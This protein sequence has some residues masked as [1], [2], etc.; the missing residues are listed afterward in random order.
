[1]KKKTDL[2]KNDLEDMATRLIPKSELHP[3]SVTEVGRLPAFYEKILAFEKIFD[4]PFGE[5]NQKF[6]NTLIMRRLQQLINTLALNPLWKDRVAQAGLQ[7]APRNLEE[8][9]QLPL[10]DKILVSDYFTGPRLGMVVPLSY[11]GFEIVASGGT[12][13]GTPSETVYS[14]RELWDTYKIAGDFIGRYVLADYLKGSEPKW[15]ITTLADYQMWSSGTMVGG[16]LQHIPSI[17]YIGAGP[18]MKEIFQHVMSYRGPKA[19]MGISQGIAILTDL[20]FDMNS[21]ARNSFRV[22]LYGSGVLPQRKREELKSLYP[23]LVIMSYFAA[24]QAET[25]GLQLNPDSYLAAVP[26]LHLIEIVD[27]DGR[28][29]AEG[30][31]GELVVTRLHAHEAP[32]LR[33]KLGDRMIR[34]PD[35]DGPGLKTQQFE[36]SGSSGDMIHLG[37]TQY[38][39]MRAYESLCRE[40]KQSGILDLETA[41]HEVQFFNDRRAKCLALIA[42]V[43]EVSELNAQ[44]ESRLGAEGVKHLFVEALIRSLS[45]FNR[46][47]ANVHYLDKTGYRFEIRFVDRLS[48]EI[49]RTALG[50][51]PLLRDIF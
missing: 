41:A 45:M 9:Q 17:N 20:G 42:A 2:D 33:F 12:S 46:G 16:V 3:T 6:R 15:M 47:E 49:H 13:S 48:P 50:K 23:N 8:W 51:T 10:S 36:F 31:E 35:L 5:I 11:G 44:I 37:D 38:M 22:A 43:D 25:I 26:G 24:T 27:D 19:F 39:A 18:L 29:V 30:E 28:W 4:T 7:K 1:M 34:R 32:V 14:L 40:L 21:E